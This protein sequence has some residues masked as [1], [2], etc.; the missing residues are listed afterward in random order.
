MRVGNRRILIIGAGV[1][2]SAAAIALR[3][4]GLE[5]E[6]HEAKSRQATQYGGCY[7]LWYAGVLSLG[8]LGLADQAYARGHRLAR[9][10]MCDAHGRVLN[11]LD[12]AARG[13][14]LGA[15]PVAIRRADL[16][17]ILYEELGEESLTLNST[18][19]GMSADSRGVT[20]T[21]TDGRTERCAVL[22]G[23][24]GLDSRVRAHLHGLTPAKYPGYAHWSGIA[25]NE[26]G[27]PADTFRVLHGKGAR[28]AFFHLGGGRVCWWCVRNAPE[29][30][31]GDSLGS[32]QALTTFFGD[33][34]PTVPGLLAA[35]PPDAIHRR[36]TLDRPL[37]RIWGKGRVTLLGD[38]AH[39]MT[40]NLGQGAGTS[41]TDAVTLAGH[42]SG[43]SPVISALRAY[44]RA[45]RSVTLPLVLASRQVGGS[46]AWGGRFGPALNNAVLR[47]IGP[48][49]T[50]GLLELDARSH[51]TL[52]RT[53][54]TAVG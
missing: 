8:R 9:F 11:S 45:R 19:R 39:A 38:A 25:E 41:L 26:A 23:A 42:L 51:A 16:L 53:A 47:S 43:G 54:G 6:V 44:E 32:Y 50:P 40:F 52:S 10:E 28:F 34:E 27:A 1:G 48:K 20:A 17:N 29:G 35:T 46:A 4:A 18:F 14:T 7:V 22:V 36:D 2:G 15:T 24:D 3:R 49:V 5:P 31:A 13:K 37:Q 12:M 21:F 33:W 30:P